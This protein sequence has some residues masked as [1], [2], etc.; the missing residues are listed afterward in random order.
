VAGG[1]RLAETSALRC[2]K[3]CG[4]LQQEIISNE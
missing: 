4:V 1:C 3:P 2:N